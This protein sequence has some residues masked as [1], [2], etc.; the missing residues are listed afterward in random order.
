MGPDCLDPMS[1]QLA[2]VLLCVLWLD[3]EKGY[4]VSGIS[5]HVLVP[6]I[7]TIPCHVRTFITCFFMAGERKPANMT[8]TLRLALFDL[9]ECGL[10]EP[11]LIKIG[12]MY[13]K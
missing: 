12:L 11:L 1:G 3:E 9:G 2:A 4:K 7:Q 5:P 6:K 10:I 8:L 13:S